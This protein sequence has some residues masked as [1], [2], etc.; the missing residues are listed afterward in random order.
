MP[1]TTTMDGARCLVV[2]ASDPKSIGYTCAL[3]LLNVGAEVCIV[4][5]DTQKLLA[6]KDT[7]N[8]NG[9]GI[10]IGDLKKPETMAKVFSTCLE[11]MKW[12]SLDVLIVSVGNGKSEYL[13]LDPKDPASYK[14][15]YDVA[16]V[17]PQFLID[18]A[19]P[20]LTKSKQRGGGSVVIVS[21][22]APH[23]PWPDTAPYN[24]ARAAQNCMIETLAFRHRLDNIRVNGV[25]PSCIHTGAL[26]IMASKKGKSVEEYAALR[27]NAHP[28][29]RNGLPEEVADAVLFLASSGASYMTGELI[30]VDGG[31]HLSSWFNRPKITKEFVGG[32]D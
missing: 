19:A 25:L 2:G 20:Y 26:D 8:T 6:A 11:T 24:Y 22:M 17:S 4:G 13:G 3:G 12:D 14:M 18:E 27:A 16:V 29:G 10:V 15:S 1:V 7:L 30:K 28:M 9:T 5:R 21:S 31:L 23:V 32:T